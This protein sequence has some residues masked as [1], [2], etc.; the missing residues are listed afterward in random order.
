MFANGIWD[1]VRISSGDIC[2]LVFVQL[3]I[4]ELVHHCYTQAL[5]VV[6][7]GSLSVKDI[8]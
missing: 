5:G 6:E 8:T 4:S 1:D 3:E 2:F 7:V